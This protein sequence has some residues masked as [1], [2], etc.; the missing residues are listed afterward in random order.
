MRR[1]KEEDEEEEEEEEGEEQ[2]QEEGAYES[3]PSLIGSASVVTFCFRNLSIGL[4]FFIQ[5][6][7]FIVDC[8]QWFPHDSYQPCCARAYT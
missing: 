4:S 5:L 3:R 6:R 2:E 8:Q 7:L 1:G